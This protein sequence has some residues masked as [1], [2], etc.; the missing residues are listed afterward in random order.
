MFRWK[1][2]ASWTAAHSPSCWQPLWYSCLVFAVLAAESR[3][4][5]PLFSRSDRVYHGT[6]NEE[7]KQDWSASVQH[8]PAEP[9]R[10]FGN[11]WTFGEQKF[12]TPIQF[13]PFR[14]PGALRK[15]KE[16]EP[17]ENRCACRQRHQP[18]EVPKR[19]PTFGNAD[20]FDGSS[21]FR[22]TLQTTPRASCGL[23]PAS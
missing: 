14:E 16:H 19:R 23:M 12:R 9:Q 13:D 11:V 18:K 8:C 5:G 6:E 17:N 3:F 21:R 2:T 1:I 7:D 15:A 4:Q 20:Q 10:Q 22:S